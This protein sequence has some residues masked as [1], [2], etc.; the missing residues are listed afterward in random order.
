MFWEQTPASNIT[1]QPQALPTSMQQFAANNSR[2]LQ[3]ILWAF[4]KVSRAICLCVRDLLTM[5]DYR[6]CGGNWNPL[7]VSVVHGQSVPPRKKAIVSVE[8]PC[9]ALSV[10]G[11][12]NAKGKTA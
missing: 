1:L 2:I 5:L 11:Y 12:S 7:S 9:A 3:K 10:C 4:P 8:C 6:F